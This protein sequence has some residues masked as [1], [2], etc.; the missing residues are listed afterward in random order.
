MQGTFEASSSGK[1]SKRTSGAAT[2]NLRRAEFAFI[3]C[4]LGTNYLGNTTFA[5]R[6]K[7]TNYSLGVRDAS[8]AQLVRSVVF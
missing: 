8:A 3:L 1:N 5:V 4:S 7:T 2:V 6:G